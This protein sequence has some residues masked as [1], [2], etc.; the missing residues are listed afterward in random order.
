MITG[1]SPN[2]INKYTIDRLVAVTAE[3]RNSSQSVL[4]AGVSQHYFYSV[5]HWTHIDVYGEQR[6][7]FDQGS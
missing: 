6:L 3:F 1:R 5:T 2:Q 4:R 7:F